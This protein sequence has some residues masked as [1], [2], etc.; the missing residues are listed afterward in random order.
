MID[1]LLGDKELSRRYAENGMKRVR[2]LFTI[3]KMIGE[4]EKCYEEQDVECHLS[5]RS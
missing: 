3:P 1:I 4:M 5:P 2:D